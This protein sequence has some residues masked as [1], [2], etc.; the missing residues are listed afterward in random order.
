M[1]GVPY[2]EDNLFQTMPEQSKGDG[3]AERAWFVISPK[4]QAA[5]PAV[6]MGAVRAEGVSAI[7]A[8]K[9]CVT[10]L[11]RRSRRPSTWLSRTHDLMMRLTGHVRYCWL[12]LAAR[13]GGAWP[14]HLPLRLRC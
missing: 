10:V 3:E 5:F 2:L 6:Q 4:M 7:A 11:S 14:E 8:A 9:H 13:R 1:E 12:L